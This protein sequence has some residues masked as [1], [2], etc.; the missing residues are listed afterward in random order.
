MGE[1]P[2]AL[3]WRQSWAVRRNGSNGILT[4]SAYREADVGISVALPIC[5]GC[6]GGFDP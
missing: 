4:R 3:G 6:R 1:E 2:M 5:E